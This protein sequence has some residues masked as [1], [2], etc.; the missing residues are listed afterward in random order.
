MILT[1]RDKL[2]L[3][4]RKRR[5]H[6]KTSPYFASLPQVRDEELAT[7]EQGQER[8]RQERARLRANVTED[9]REA[10]NKWIQQI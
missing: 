2:Q 8:R 3:Q 5:K 1:D 10:Y 9:T 4:T 6:T 7:R